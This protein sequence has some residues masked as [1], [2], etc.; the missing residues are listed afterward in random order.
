MLR[1]SR[2]IK[3]NS[4]VQP[5]ALDPQE[6]KNGT[7]VKI[8]GW[9][10]LAAKGSGSAMLMK[11]TVTVLDENMCFQVSGYKRPDMLCLSHPLDN[12]S[13]Y[14]DSGSGAV[15]NGKL[16]GVASFILDDC[17]SKYPDGYSKISHNYNWIMR[18]MA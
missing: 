18:N 12:G 2:D 16:I 14:G 1:I 9:G 15:Y 5:I 17:G 13:C 8:L 7:Q 10:R 6:I 3:F 4:R 11:N